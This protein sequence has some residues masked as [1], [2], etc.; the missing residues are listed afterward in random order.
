MKKIKILLMEDNEEG[1]IVKK[2]LQLL[3]NEGTSGE[4]V[5]TG[6]LEISDCAQKI[7]EADVIVFSCPKMAGPESLRQTLKVVE[8]INKMLDKNKIL[9]VL[10]WRENGWE[11]QMREIQKRRNRS[12]FFVKMRES[13]SIKG[14]NILLLA[15]MI[16]E[17]AAA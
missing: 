7:N 10:L 17:V 9:I 16:E 6:L 14:V 11:K 15:K 1:W 12:A 13:N 5:K 4:H 2:W 3:A 8:K